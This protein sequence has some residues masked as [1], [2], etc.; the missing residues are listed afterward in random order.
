MEK[1]AHKSSRSASGGD[2][3]VVNRDDRV[4]SSETAPSAPKTLLALGNGGDKH[5]REVRVH[6]L[7]LRG[8]ELREARL[9]AFEF[10]T[11]LGCA[12]GAADRVHKVGDGIAQG[13]EVGSFE[14]GH[15]KV[16]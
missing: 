3:G 4:V 11:D 1:V 16:L 14:L 8:V 2:V 13:V 15:I 10:P 9:E 7:R 6:A 12:N 5:A